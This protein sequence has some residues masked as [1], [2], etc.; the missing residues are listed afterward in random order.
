MYF[1]SLAYG[2]CKM[3]NDY[4]S[5]VWIPFCGVYCCIAWFSCI[6]YEVQKCLECKIGLWLSFFT[7]ST[8]WLNFVVS[9]PYGHQ[10]FFKKVPNGKRYRL[11]YEVQM[12]LEGK[13]TPV[14]SVWLG[15]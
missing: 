4:V 10:G 6:A 12:C 1:I 11:A 9:T 15:F 14:I 8:A 13:T 7:G 5:I 3:K 2:V